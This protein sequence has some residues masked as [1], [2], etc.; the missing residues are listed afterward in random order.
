MLPRRRINVESTIGAFMLGVV[1]GAAIVAH[2]H[3][4]HPTA[5]ELYGC[6]VRDQAPNGECE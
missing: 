2:D 1:L 4:R 3:K 5:D 6:T